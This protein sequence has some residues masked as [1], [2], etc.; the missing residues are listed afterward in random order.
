M[1]NRLGI[2]VR[3]NQ[4]EQQDLRALQ[5]FLKVPDPKQALKIAFYQLVEALKQR[6][7][8]LE[9]EDAAA[10]AAEEAAQASEEQPVPAEVASVDEPSQVGV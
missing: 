4:A 5:Q 7:R 2:T 3:L 8:Q 6:Q 1:N 10:A 9:A